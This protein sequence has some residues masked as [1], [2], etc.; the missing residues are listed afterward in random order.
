MMEPADHREGDDFPSIDRLALARFG[1]VLIEREVGSGS[2]I[3]LDVLPQDAPQVLLSEDDDV[4][5][6]LPPKGPDHALPIG[7]H[8]G[9]LALPRAWKHRRFCG[10]RGSEEAQR[11][12]RPGLITGAHPTDPV[13]RTSPRL[14]AA[15]ILVSRLAESR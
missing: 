4:V 7:K 11:I 2:V 8:G 12:G 5:E 15:W 9:R 6:A 3:V 13:S 14:G 10:R 1:G